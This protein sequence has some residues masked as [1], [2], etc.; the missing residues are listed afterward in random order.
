MPDATT[1]Q[2]NMTP[3]IGL[4]QI[5]NAKQIHRLATSRKRVGHA[6]HLRARRG[7]V[8]TAPISDLGRAGSDRHCRIGQRAV[9]RHCGLRNRTGVR[10]SAHVPGQPVALDC[11]RPAAP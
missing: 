4:G 11:L 2:L 3:L 7:C 1:C 8:V 10:T 6:R 9:F 5:Y